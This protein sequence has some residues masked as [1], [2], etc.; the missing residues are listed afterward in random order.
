MR[1]RGKDNE[2]KVKQVDRLKYPESGNILVLKTL[3]DH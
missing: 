2:I 1:G 3:A